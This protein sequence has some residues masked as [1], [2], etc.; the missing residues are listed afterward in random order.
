MAK[1]FIDTNDFTVA[2][3]NAMVDLISL[4]KE[5]DRDGCVPALLHRRSLGMIF[6]EP[7]PR[8]RVSF[9]V[10]MAK[11]GGH[12]LYLRPGAEGWPTLNADRP[13]ERPIIGPV[14]CGQ[15]AGR[16]WG[17]AAPPPLPHAAGQAGHSG[18]G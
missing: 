1:D 16:A 14:R 5:A 7:S 15:A 4:L 2:E 10:A 6:E 12:A 18:R 11:L 9:E 17:T 3:L 8:T 13:Y